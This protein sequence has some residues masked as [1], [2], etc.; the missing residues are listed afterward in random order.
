MD[1]RLEKALEF[2]NIRLAQSVERRRLTEKFK[3][4]LT[5][6]YNGGIFYIDRTLLIFLKDLKEK[7]EYG[8]TIILDDKL[9]PI[10]ISN[11]TEFA[12]K[13]WDIYFN[14]TKQY[15]WD[16]NVLKKRRKVQDIVGYE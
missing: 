10:E 3:Q 4:E 7:F 13:I 14:S 6:A 15:L 16:L 5:Y 11:V 9:N 12:D 1:D 2:S 8:S